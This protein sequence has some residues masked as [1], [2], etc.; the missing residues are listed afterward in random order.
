MTATAISPITGWSAV[1]PKE[2]SVCYLPGVLPADVSLL[3]NEAASR[4]REGDPTARNI[5]LWLLSHREHTKNTWGSYNPAAFGVAAQKIS[6][7][8]L[9]RVFAELH[10]VKKPR[11]MTKKD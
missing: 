9:A 2:A 4:Y 5:L 7:D 3:Q 11:P 10:L 6:G 1:S 8:E